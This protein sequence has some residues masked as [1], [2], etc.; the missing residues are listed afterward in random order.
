MRKMDK[1]NKRIIYFILILIC[2]ITVFIFSSENGEESQNTSDVAFT[3]RIINVITNIFPKTNRT[4]IFTAVNFIVR[5]G[6]HFTLY[7]IMGLVVYRAINTY[8]LGTKKKIIL[9]ISVGTLYACLD[10]F[11]QFFVPG[12]S[13]QIRD[14]F[15][16]MLGVIL[17]TLI[18]CLILYKKGE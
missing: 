10:E 12:R 3:N 9:T 15:I 14:I 17:A 16:D 6:A 7:F 2:M 8:S 13:A 11:H 5:K 1:K 18:V 4:D